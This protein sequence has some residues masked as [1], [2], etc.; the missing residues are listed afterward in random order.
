MM[1]D[2]SLRVKTAAF[3]PLLSLIDPANKVDVTELDLRQL[4]SK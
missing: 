4:F 3:E 1:E 2:K